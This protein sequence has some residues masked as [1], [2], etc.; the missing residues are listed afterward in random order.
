MAKA[1]LIV[2]SCSQCVKGL[3]LWP[4]VSLILALH[5]QVFSG[6]VGKIPFFS[7]TVTPS[8]CVCLSQHTVLMCHM[9]EVVQIVSIAFGTFEK[10]Y[11]C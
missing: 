9:K 2:V 5:C 7:P 11:M 1:H 3:L 6:T 4:K 8:V 10:N